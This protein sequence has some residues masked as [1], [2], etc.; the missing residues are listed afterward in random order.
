MI[1]LEYTIKDKKWLDFLKQINITNYFKN[2]FNKTITTLE[3]KIPSKK[4]IEI[5][6]TFTGDEAIKKINKEFRNCDKS[7]NVLSFPTYEKEFLTILKYE[8]YLPI[9]DII[10]SFETIERESKEQNKAFENHLTH[11]IIHSLLHLFGFD[12]IQ[13]EDANI[14]ENLE[15]N[16]LKQL[17]IDNPYL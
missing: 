3:Y 16:I 8:D 5:S 7:T 11:L 13:D 1:K 14:M 17:N 2:I 9:G 15:I 12:H 10:L 4:I 6:I